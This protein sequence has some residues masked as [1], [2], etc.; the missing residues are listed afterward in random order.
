MPRRP[1]PNF[2]LSLP[3]HHDADFRSA[4]EE[5]QQRIADDPPSGYHPSI[6]IQGQRLHLTLGVLLLYRHEPSS[7]Y[8]KPIGEAID[9]LEECRPLIKDYLD[10]RAVIVNIDGLDTFQEH[11]AGQSVCWNE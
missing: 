3:L 11:H 9:L 1:R 8:D 6:A 7:I 10:G 4:V 2:F 5:F